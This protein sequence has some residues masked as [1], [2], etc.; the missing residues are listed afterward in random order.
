ME[1]IYT[2]NNV[3]KLDNILRVKLNMS[4]N[5]IKKCEKDI[6]VNGIHKFRNEILNMGDIIHITLKEEIPVEERFITK[7]TC[8]EQKPDIIYE[9]QYIL[10]VNKPA[11]MPVHPSIGNYE[12][13]LSNVV[14]TYLAIQE[15]YGIH[16]ITRLDKDTSG[17]CIFAKHPYVQELFNLKKEEICLNKEYLCVVDGLVE[18]PHGIIEAPI[19]RKQGSIILREVNENGKYAKTEYYVED[20][21]KNKNYS[22][23]KVI[24]HTGRTH[25]IR[26]HMSSIGHVLLG[27][28]LYA[29]ESNRENILKLINRQ[30]LHCK[31]ISFIHP[32]T[33]EQIIL[34][35]DVPED[36][37]NITN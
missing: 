7:Y 30:A 13:T 10:V 17:V 11:N 19:A 22:V 2:V 26:V 36:I 8:H 23:L 24:L 4:R 21:N 35:A 32:I 12:H 37:K 25:Q 9:D 27:D 31:C 14:A 28:D 5:V 33:K 3:E 1:I 20:I 34:K 15:I 6:K 18:E 16:I 29:K